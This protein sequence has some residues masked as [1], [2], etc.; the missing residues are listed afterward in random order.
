[1]SGTR[2]A[3]IPIVPLTNS[4]F[5]QL[6]CMEDVYRPTGGTPEIGDKHDDSAVMRQAYTGMCD[7]FDLTQEKDRKAYAEL[8][9]KLFAGTEYVRLWEERT[10]AQDGKYYVYVAYVRVL[11]VYQTGND[12]FDLNDKI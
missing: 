9:A 1:M 6:E 5:E 11:N 12:S 4:K 8:I 7:R 3:D 2:L 10:P